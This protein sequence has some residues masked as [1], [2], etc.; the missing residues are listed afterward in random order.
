MEYKHVTEGESLHLCSFLAAVTFCTDVCRIAKTIIFFDAF[1]HLHVH[2][3][4]LAHA[5]IP[6]SSQ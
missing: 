1:S 2:L 3:S 6:N 5:V 4:M